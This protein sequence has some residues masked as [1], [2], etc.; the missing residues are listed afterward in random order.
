M[1]SLLRK[2]CV[3]A[4]VAASVGCGAEPGETLR[5]RHGGQEYRVTLDCGPEGPLLREGPD[6]ERVAA[7]FTAPRSGYAPDPVEPDLLWAYRDDEEREQVVAH[8]RDRPRRAHPAAPIGPDELAF[9]PA[10]LTLFRETGYGGQS[11]FRSGEHADGDLRGIGWDNHISSLK[12]RGTQVILYEHT[13]WR[14]RSL[15]LLADAEDTVCDQDIRD[16]PS[17]RDFILFFVPG[18][19]AR[20]VT[21]DNQATS[22]LLLDTR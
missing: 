3:V 12:F 1:L 4:L 18:P 16:V 11:F 17:L 14:G 10:S 7:L 2:G 6:N 19:G 20:P 21:W 22:L 9:C 8:L 5:L 15:S 13:E